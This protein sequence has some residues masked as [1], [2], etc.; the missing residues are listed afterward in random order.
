MQAIQK[1]RYETN[2]GVV[3]NA[4]AFDICLMLST[5][6]KMLKHNLEDQVLF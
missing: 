2:H 4:A 1:L 5:L 3:C 6:V